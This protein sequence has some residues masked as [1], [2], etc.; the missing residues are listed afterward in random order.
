MKAVGQAHSAVLAKGVVRIQTSMRV[1][2]RTDR[3]QVGPEKIKR[4]QDIL[5]KD[6]SA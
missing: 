6:S 4:V 1:G 5:A 3:K 2:T